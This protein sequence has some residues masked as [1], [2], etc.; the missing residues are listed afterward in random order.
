M[1]SKQNKYIAFGFLYA[2]ALMLFAILLAGA[3]HGTAIFLALFMS[4]YLIG[5][6]F[7]PL[8]GY[9]LASIDSIGKRRML[10]GLV[11][12]QYIGMA[13]WLYVLG[14]DELVHLTRVWSS[15]YVLVIMALA[16]YLAGQFFIWG[17]I[18][19]SLNNR[20]HSAV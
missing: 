7:W 8:I 6:F 14:A 4:P 2:I 10:I 1:T 20:N 5:F 9:L 13:H 12:V 15:A 3:G 18:A 16:L 11:I 17:R 19:R